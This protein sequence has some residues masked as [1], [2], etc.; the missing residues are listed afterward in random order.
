MLVVNNVNNA[1]ENNNRLNLSV[2]DFDHISFVAEISRIITPIPIPQN[3]PCIMAAST[4]VEISVAKRTMHRNGER[5]TPKQATI[6]PSVLCSLYPTKIEMFAAIIPGRDW[7]I[8][9]YSTSSS[10]VISLYFSTNSARSIG[11][12]TYPPPKRI[13]PIL[14]N[15]KNNFA[16]EIFIVIYLYKSNHLLNLL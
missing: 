4:K 7:L 3:K 16:N 6:A 2:T 5:F 15:I 11:K 9:K 8:A 12:M 1:T 13:V 10:S 14:T